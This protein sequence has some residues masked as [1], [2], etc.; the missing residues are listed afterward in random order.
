MND[1]NT[2]QS[3]RN[4]RCKDSS[5]SGSSFHATATPFIPRL[6][7]GIPNPGS[8]YQ[9]TP[10]ITHSGPDQPPSPY[11]P[12]ESATFMP[13][14]TPAGS[15]LPS[16][17]FLGPEEGGTH[18]HLDGSPRDNDSGGVSLSRER[19]ATSPACEVFS[20]GISEDPTSSPSGHN[21][22]ISDLGPLPP[23]GF[24]QAMHSRRLLH[25]QSI[26]DQSWLQDPE[27]KW[28]ETGR[29]HSNT[30]IS[31]GALSNGERRGRS[32]SQSTVTVD[33]T[34]RE[35][36]LQSLRDVVKRPIQNLYTTQPTVYHTLSLANQQ[37]SMAGISMDQ[38]FRSSK[39]TINR[40]SRAENLPISRANPLVSVRLGIQGSPLEN[41]AEE[42]GMRLSIGHDYHLSCDNQRQH[43]EP[44]TRAGNIVR[45]NAHSG[46]TRSNLVKSTSP[47]NVHWDQTLV[48][49][50]HSDIYEG[51]ADASSYH[52]GYNLNSHPNVASLQTHGNPVDSL[53]YDQSQLEHLNVV[54]RA[55]AATTPLSFRRGH[56]EDVD[57]R[58][59]HGSSGEQGFGE[60]GDITT[61]V[62]ERAY[63][64][65]PE[66]ASEFLEQSAN[67]DA[68]TERASAGTQAP[69]PPN[70]LSYT[71][72][73][74]T[75]A[76]QALHMARNANVTQEPL[77]T[78][79]SPIG[80]RS[81]PS[82]I[83]QYTARAYRQHEAVP[84]QGQVDI[85]Q[86]R[87]QDHLM[88]NYTAMGYGQP[89][90]AA[91]SSDHRGYGQL[92]YGHSGFTQH[93]TDTLGYGPGYYD[94]RHPPYNAGFG[95][96]MQHRSGPEPYLDTLSSYPYQGTPQPR[97]VTRYVRPHLPLQ[98]HSSEYLHSPYLGAALLPGQ[99]Q[100]ALGSGHGFLQHR[101]LL[102]YLPQPIPEWHQ[103]QQ[104]GAQQPPAVNAPT[105][106]A[107]RLGGVNSV[108][109]YK[110]GM[111]SMP[112]Y[113]RP[114]HGSS[115]HHHSPRIQL[116]N[117]MVTEQYPLQEL[118]LEPASAAPTVPY[119]AGTDTM[120][121]MSMGGPSSKYQDL[122]S[123]G[124]PSFE[125]ASKKMPFIELARHAKPAEWGVLR[126][127]NIPYSVTKQEILAFLG[128]NAKII[129][130]DLGCA[131]HIIME[132]ATG[133][134]MDCFVEFLSSGDALAAV[135]RFVRH[136]EEGRSGRIGDRHVDV[137]MS[138]QDS[139]MK[140]LFPRAKNVVWHGA[141][142]AIFH[143]TEPFNSGF[144]GFITSEEMVMTVKHA[145]T[146]HRSPFSH[147]CLQRT[148]ESM[149]SVLAKYPWWVVESYTLADRNL[150][151]RATEQ[152]VRAL[153]GQLM[154]GGNMSPQM[155]EQLLT[156]LVYAGLNA[157]GF[158][159]GQRAQ[160]VGSADWIGG[161][162]RIS[163]LASVWP[164][165]VLGRKP[166]TD[167]DVIEYFA[168]CLR[169]ATTSSALVS[170]AELSLRGAHGAVSRPFGNVTV[171]WPANKENMTMAA[172]AALEWGVVENLLRKV[173]GG[174]TEAS[175][176]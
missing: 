28:I 10:L 12:L 61:R 176:A 133:K 131:I 156:E 152:L 142:P 48:P 91:Y 22:V 90:P 37:E 150:L 124:Q 65:A 5:S 99:S 100:N 110:G 45:R 76:T 68:Y 136:K 39:P 51:Q 170:L 122:T 118:A 66:Y 114:M 87:P 135:N 111:P 102:Q 9:P 36:M 171:S 89:N 126:I 59:Q 138:G 6:A 157:P 32:G 33:P 139:L 164:F 34:A 107:L 109:Q 26:W 98:D 153:V 13:P 18:E 161:R 106:Q 173:L 3:W 151:F 134:T 49:S 146:P 130:P 27:R 123:R 30:T 163:P 7:P 140:E 86:L 73:E 159:E 84:L 29:P 2:N 149:I 16:P 141:D 175:Q 128:R 1:P 20:A 14:D 11:Y 93:N 67:K 35:K 47:A 144:K 154:R 21:R 46:P 168:A 129:T 160:L 103:P 95:P 125:E 155:N 54:S 113:G 60:Y 57:L 143:S 116:N 42:D 43:L 50:A 115:V 166:D 119:R 52:M 101:E 147:K 25:E 40:D 8:F 105:E 63:T 53:S 31:P 172:A 97:S 137:E 121:P 79:Q 64:L 169:Q 167:E 78:S 56:G 81:F 72:P 117:Q 82:N 70:T 162:I 94:V 74:R 23:R 112:H 75:L 80:L 88:P 92:N 174:A 145:E 132:R 44:E 4:Q 71:L 158:S 77:L 127:G 62:R 41:V 85:P 19:S 165:E 83:N 24:E 69:Q 104:F 38:N 15:A 96:H 148:Y 108:Q 55:R 120:Y 17:S 58:Q